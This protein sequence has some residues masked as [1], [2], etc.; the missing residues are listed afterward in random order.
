MIPKEF[1]YD[2]A[3]AIHDLIAEDEERDNGN[4]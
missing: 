3:S 4:Q 2:E 1:F